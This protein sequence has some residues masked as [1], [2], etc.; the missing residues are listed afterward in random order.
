MADTIADVGTIDAE[1]VL[2]ERRVTNEFVIQEIQENVR[3]KFVRATVELGP[4]TEETRFD[5]QVE[6][7]GSGMRTV[8]VWQNEDYDAVRDTWRNEDLIA[9][10]KTKLG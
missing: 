2:S 9:A 5:G 1:I 8:T 10:V 7:R 3:N 4:F 6:L